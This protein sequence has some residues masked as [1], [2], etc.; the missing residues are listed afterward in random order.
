MDKS[1]VCICIPNFNN[2]KTISDTLDSILNQ[3][4]KNTIIKIFDN[5]STDKSMEIL[6]DYEKRYKNIKVFQNEKNI[7]GEANFTKCIEGLEGDFG[8]IYHTDDIYHPK[9]IET[10]VNYLS[11]NDISA[12]FVRAN[13]IDDN[14]NNIG[15]Q[16]F[17]EKL[18]DKTYHQFNFQELFSL[19]LQ[20]DNFLITPSVMARTDIYKDK[21]K[22]WNGEKFKTSAD[23]DVWLRFSEIKDIGIITEKLISY[24]MS[25]ASFSYRT[26]FS[27]TVP[28]DMFLVLDYYMEKYNNLDFDKADY[29][30]LKFKDNIMVAGN[31][32]LN[33]KSIKS[34]DIKL[35]DINIIKKTVLDKQKIKIYVYAVLL[36][37]LL[38]LNFKKYLLRLV[39]SVNNIE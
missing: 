18:K 34:S 14:S 4:Y 21:I 36:K 16:F 32:I 17:P 9:M 24:R 13:L 37:I 19:I 12:V 3:T 23:L 11:K 31:K 6:K 1:L 5:V 10:Q 39:K 26:K 33:N 29:E 7:G 2:E 28:R 27:R 22:S 30:Y 8:A 38:F 35:F 15:E 20:Y 25:T